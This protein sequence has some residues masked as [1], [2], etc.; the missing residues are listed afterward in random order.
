MSGLTFLNPLGLTS[1]ILFVEWD[2]DNLLHVGEDM[3]PSFNF[4]ES[5]KEEA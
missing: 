1:P 4:L 5:F 3:G 2:R